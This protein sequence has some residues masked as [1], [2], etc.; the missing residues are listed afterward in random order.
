MT[1]TR[2]MS[3]AEKEAAGIWEPKPVSAAA[4]LGQKF[5]DVRW[6]IEKILPDGTYI[7]AA[8]PKV[9]KS[10]FA[11]QLSIAV[12]CRLPMLGQDTK[13]GSVLYLALEDNERRIQRRLNKLLHDRLVDPAS[14]D[15][16]HFETRWRRGIDGAADLAVWLEGHTDC[17][18]VVIDTLERIRNSRTA[19]GAVYAEDYAAIAPFKAL[20]DRFG[21]AILI[22]HHTRKSDAD[23]PLEQVSG[24]LGLTGSADGVLV[25]TKPRGESRGELHVIGRDIEQE[26]AFIVEFGKDTCMWTMVGESHEVADTEQQ[27]AV[28]DCIREL[29]PIQPKDIAAEIERKDAT[30]R[31]FLQK[32][33]KSG[34]VAKTSK[35]YVL[36]GEQDEQRERSEQIQGGTA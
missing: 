30:V 5:R 27:Q 26:G 9:G 19:S 12:A 15:R 28:L 25:L 17:R 22:V 36:S 31:R 16:L 10:W 14:L 8:K 11:L 18:L 1:V 13:Q 3:A 33:R 21:V 6:V 7:L 4:I 24:T 29:G 20:S 2:P 32:L 23:D 34:R 35:G